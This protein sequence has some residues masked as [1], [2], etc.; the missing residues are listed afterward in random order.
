MTSLKEKRK[1]FQ[2]PGA[3]YRGKPFW[4]WN[5]ELDEKELKRQ[6]H[7]IKEMGFGGA[8]MHSR[9]GLITEY[10]GEEWFELTNISADEGDKLGL[11]MWLYDEDRWPSGSAGGKVTIE[12]QYRMKSL[13][14]TELVPERFSMNADYII[15][16][17]AKMDGINIHT[18]RRIMDD[19]NVEDVLEHVK[20]EY[21]SLPGEWKVLAFSIVPDA[22]SSNY[23]G[24]TYI[25]TMSLAATK[26]FLELTHEQYVAHCSKRIGT[27]IRGIFTDEP[28]RGQGMG[29]YKE[30]DGIITCS[31]AWT[32][33]LFE[34]FI[35]RYGYDAREVLPELFYRPNGERFSP[36]KHDYFDLADNL[37]LERFAKPIHEW[38][39]ANNMILTGHVLHEDSLTNQ[40]A[41]H[42]S[43][44]R[45]YEYMDYPG[46]DVL[47]NN[48]K[49]YW[50]VKQ[51]TSVARQLG[52]TW[53]LSELYGCTGWETSMRDQKII[54]DW[55]T[56]LGINIR[57]HHLSWYTMEG[58]AKRD[59]PGS[60]LHQAAWYPYYDGVESYFARFGQFMSQGHAMCDV[61][62]LNPI[63]SAWSQSYA[64]W[65]NWIH[66]ASTEVA[67]LEG[68]Y[69][70]LFH[71]LME[72]HID[73]DYG[74]EQM[75]AS[76]YRIDKD[77]TGTAL[78]HIGQA[79]YRV[80]VVG[81]MM[82]IRP[83]T[84]C[85]LD[86][87]M[88]AGGKV[89]FAGEV[90][91]YVNAR[92]S[93]EPAKLAS[94]AICIPF[95]EQAL[96]SRVREF[97]DEY[98]D[99]VNMDGNVEKEVLVQCRKL[100]EGMAFAVLNLNTDETKDVVIRLKNTGDYHCEFWELESGNCYN[101]DAS[102]LQGVQY[103]FVRTNLP[104]AGT[105]AFVL[106]TTMDE[107]LPVLPAEKQM[108]WEAELSDDTAENVFSYKLHEP[109]V[110]VLDKVRWRMDGGMWS[111]EQEILK[112][113][114]QVRDFVG[115]ERRSGSMLQ[116]WYAKSM[117]N[118]IYGDLEWQFTFDIEEMPSENIWLAGER[119]EQIQY[120]VNG[121][122]LHCTDMDRFWIDTCFKMMEI[123]ADALKYGE[124]TVTLKTPFRRTTNMEAIYLLGEF[125]VQ[126][127]R[128]QCALT[129]LPGRIGY[130]SLTEY[131]LPFY[132][133]EITYYL[134]PKQYENHII[135]QKDERIY[136]SARAEHA[137]LV[138][139]KTSQGEKL[140]FWEPYEIDV[141][142]ALK[143]GETIEVTVV[144]NRRN[145][146]GPLHLLP[147]RKIYYSPSAYV[148]VGE[149][150]SDEYEL[151]DNA[152]CSLK[153]SGYKE[154]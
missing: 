21:A 141:T 18:Y 126:F 84:L 45:Y 63:E 34:E 85:I 76:M 26:R 44:M 104:A 88:Q 78:L 38:C 5:G 80:V 113:D 61:L 125:G 22:C 4:S 86:E 2:C 108:L 50:I 37:F 137:S 81:G 114:R 105:K 49:K 28:H 55:Q 72:H 24:T 14:I 138:K 25:D 133:G 87:F 57:C 142:D 17:V 120:Y 30:E 92:A 16:F 64:G 75:M 12:P 143:N 119:P 20:K 7:I 67:E 62:V 144:G 91:A 54:G 154:G 48:N 3:A 52:K 42:G 23:N 29:D 8:F 127:N 66:T 147:K 100:E 132:T 135:L 131:G 102:M 15:V 93:E 40:V 98:I 69:E 123:P 39:K 109:N 36:V 111:Q 139:I 53:L 82:T 77:E 27:S 101:A 56:L 150:W 96:V 136:L 90:P 1:A 94:K 129:R 79:T 146:F 106:H 35:K 134:E 32:D 128:G 46:V 99:I 9:A 95:E 115:I 60:M 112:A 33:D 145:T 118:P 6:I 31:M 13:R 70:R 152:L 117:D 121:V 74:E 124:N 71:I 19:E 89:V 103:I 41:P 11:E 47:Q 140:S 130:R 122:R 110:C 43:V 10:L 59:F 153:L 148:T 58:E 68:T 151:L 83:S 97:S 149:N 116:P 73:F 51:L 107:T 65:A